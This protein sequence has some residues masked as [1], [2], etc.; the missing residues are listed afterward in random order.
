[1]EKYKFIYI[2]RWCL[3]ISTL[4]IQPSLKLFRIQFDVKLIIAD[5]IINWR[6]MTR[7]VWARCQKKTHRDSVTSWQQLKTGNSA[8][9]AMLHDKAYRGLGKFSPAITLS[10]TVQCY[11]SDRW[12]VGATSLVIAR[13][14]FNELLLFSS[15]AIIVTLSIVIYDKHFCVTTQRKKLKR[16]YF[17]PGQWS[18]LAIIARVRA[19]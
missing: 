15:S 5:E 6:T 8:I 18:N 10:H 3:A 7:N 16:L 19:K 9:R 12:R 4:A 2:N 11:S 17:L 14:R 13:V 1:M